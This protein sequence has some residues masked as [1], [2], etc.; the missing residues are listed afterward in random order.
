MVSAAPRGALSPARNGRDGLKHLLGERDG[1]RNYDQVWLP[2]DDILATQDTLG[3]M[4]AAAQT[5]ELQLF[6]P[7]LH[8]ASHYAHYIDMRN[9]SFFAR[10]VGFVEVMLPG[11]SHAALERLLPTLELSTTG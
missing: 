9:H 3:A 4:S 7:A 1:W 2:D 5:L 8:E 11:F 10:R 6:A